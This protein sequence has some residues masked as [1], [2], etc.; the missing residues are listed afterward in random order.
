MKEA[1]QYCEMNRHG[2]PVCLGRLNENCNEFSQYG[3]LTFRSIL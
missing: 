2:L 3:K 1:E